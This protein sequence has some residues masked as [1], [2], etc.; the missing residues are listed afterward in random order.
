MAYQYTITDCGEYLR[1]EVHG[2]RKGVDVARESL[3]MWKEVADTCQ[4]QQHNLILA[5]FYLSGMRSLMDTFNIVEGVQ[6]MLWP[7]LAI[8]YVDMDPENREENTMAE[9]SAMIHGI[10]FR[11]FLS[12]ESASSWLKAMHSTSLH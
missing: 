7:E 2:S 1:L 10:N 12:E 11:T 9:Q 8:A 6:D 3:T 5:V 4:K